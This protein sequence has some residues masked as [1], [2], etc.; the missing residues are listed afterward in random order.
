MQLDDSVKGEFVAPPV[1]RFGL[2]KWP[3]HPGGRSSPDRTDE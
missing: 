2:A 3:T 1:N